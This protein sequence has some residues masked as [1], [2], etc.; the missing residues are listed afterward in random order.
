VSPVGGTEPGNY[1][2]FDHHSGQLRVSRELSQAVDMSAVSDRGLGERDYF[3]L[4]FKKSA[5]FLSRPYLVV[6]TGTQ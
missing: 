1:I 3:I 6:D 4:F 2:F 5:P